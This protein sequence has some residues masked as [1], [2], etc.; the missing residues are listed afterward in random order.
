MRWQ[1]SKCDHTLALDLRS[2]DGRVEACA[3]CGT[4]E[5]YKKKDFPHWLGML[6]LAA[7]SLGF[8]A[9]HALY[10]PWLAW[11]VLLGSAA[12]DGILYLTV[13]D[14]IVCYR[15]G[16]HYRGLSPGSSHPPFELIIAERYRQERIRRAQL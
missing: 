6:I 11:A 4:A 5:L 9:L 7:A 8:V 10:L 2:L 3:V 12:I 1:C 13:G 14:A 15:C 16:A